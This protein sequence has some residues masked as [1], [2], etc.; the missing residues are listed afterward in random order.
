MAIDPIASSANLGT[1]ADSLGLNMQS[2]LQIILTQL[3]YQDPL[4]PSTTSSSYRN[5]HSSRR[6]SRAGR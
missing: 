2:L 6:S 5:L 1:R 3:T 4:K